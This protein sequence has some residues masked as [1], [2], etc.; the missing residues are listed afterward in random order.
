MT[1]APVPAKTSANVPMNSPVNFLTCS[2][3]QTPRCPGYVR[4]ES[5][6][7]R[8]CGQT[9]SHH[10]SIFSRISS[11]MTRIS[12]SFSS[13]LPLNRSEEHTSELQSR[14]YLVCRLLLEKTQQSDI[15]D[16]HLE[17]HS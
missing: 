13:S 12:R 10:A 7:V 2:E 15:D 9:S 14:Q 4:C 8:A 3:T 17:Q 5:R 6:R 11:R 16:L 1:I